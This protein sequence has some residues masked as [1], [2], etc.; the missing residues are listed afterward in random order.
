VKRGW[1]NGEVG[2][3][4]SGLQVAHLPARLWAEGG[5]HEMCLFQEMDEEVNLVLFRRS[6]QDL[7]QIWYL[8]I[9]R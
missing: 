4:M 2:K 6:L 3:G 7:R 8:L 1:C 9:P 5:A